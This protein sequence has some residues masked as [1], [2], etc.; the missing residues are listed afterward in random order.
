[1]VAH[2]LGRV[3]HHADELDRADEVGQLER[4]DDR[5]AV[6]LPAFE[7]GQAGLDLAFGEQLHG[8]QLSGRDRVYATARVAPPAGMP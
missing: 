7:L 8:P 4:L 6:A 5:L 2:L 1:M 3:D